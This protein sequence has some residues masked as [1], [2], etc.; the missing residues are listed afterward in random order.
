MEKYLSLK[1]LR[2]LDYC[3]DL[4]VKRMDDKIWLAKNVYSNSFDY[5]NIYVNSIGEQYI[6]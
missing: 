2:K 4:N 5:F 3:L 6:L 1:D